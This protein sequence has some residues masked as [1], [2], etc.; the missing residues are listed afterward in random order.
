M[1]FE[2]R[3]EELKDNISEKT[4]K[5]LVKISVVIVFIIIALTIS[6]KIFETVE[7]GTYQIRQAA[8]TGTMNAKMTPGI[9]FELFGDIDTWPKAFT[10]Y[11]THDQDTKDDTDEN[12]SIEVRFVDGSTCEI[13]GTA[14]VLMPTSKEE[15]ISIVT[16]H[17]YTS[18]TDLERKLILPTIRNVLRMT[19]NMMTAQE[20]Y[21]SKRIDFYNWSKEQIEK[22]IFDTEDEIREVVDLVSGEKVKK[23]FK[24]RKTID[25]KPGS[26]PVHLI[27]PLEGTGILLKNFE[28]KSFVYAPKVRDQ[29]A[30]QQEALMAVATA[31]A[32]AKKAEQEKLTIAAQG[33]AKVAKA[34]YE[35]EQEKIRAV[36]D[37]EKEKEVFELNAQRDKQVAIIAAQQ[38]KEAAKLDKEAAEYKKKEQI[39]LGQGEAERKRLVLTADGALAQKLA[40][41]ESVMKIW[42]EAYSTRK[43]PAVMMGGSSGKAGVDGDAIQM[44]EVLSLMALKQLGLDLTVPKG[45]QN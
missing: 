28:I 11:F 41:Y 31:V 13:S 8:I 14:R 32:D 30:K 39:L 15:A 18:V 3:M 45:R 7:K 44:S 12:L 43:V 17:G 6:S 9:W 35:K 16:E 26:E 22:G 5:K 29:I 36:V 2:D 23:T 25:G 38:R 1:D 20:S 19:A 27:N 42:A 33:K 4:K 24:V 40:T 34:Q 21:A 37:A 10:F